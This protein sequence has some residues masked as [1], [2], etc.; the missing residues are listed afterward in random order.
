MNTYV[1]TIIIDILIFSIFLLGIRF[2]KRT[3][4][5]KIEEVCP[6]YKYNHKLHTFASMCVAMPTIL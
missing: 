2:C 4:I 6:W 1:I 3:V 5:E